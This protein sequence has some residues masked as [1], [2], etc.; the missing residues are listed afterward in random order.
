MAVISNGH[1]SCVFLDYISGQL[2]NGIHHTYVA[3][4]FHELHAHVCSN[5]IFVWQHTY[6]R[7]TYM[8]EASYEQY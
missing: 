6:T 5:D 1:L 2:H 7:Y 4:V 3:S 8:C